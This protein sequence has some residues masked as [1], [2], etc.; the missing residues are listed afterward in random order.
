MGAEACTP[1]DVAAPAVVAAPPAS[2]QIG[3]ASFGLGTLRVSCDC[4]KLAT[5]EGK[6]DVFGVGACA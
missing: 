2:F 6:P 3:G 5:P 4:G 1:A